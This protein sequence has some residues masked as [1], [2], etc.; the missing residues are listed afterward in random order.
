MLNK[1][2][3]L[4]CM[5]CV[6][7]SSFPVFALK[8]EESL[9]ID[10]D[11][12][13]DS[14]GSVVYD[15]GEVFKIT[16]ISVL[17]SN[18]AIDDFIGFYV[19]MS[20]D[21]EHYSM[22]E[23]VEKSSELGFASTE[24]TY[25]AKPAVY[26]RHIRL[27]FES[28]GTISIDCIKVK[29]YKGNNSEKLSV[30]Y[31]YLTT[32]PF[33]TGD[34]IILEDKENIVLTDGNKDIFITSTSEYT[35][36]DF[37]LQGAYAI[38]SINV[39]SMSSADCFIDGYELLYS[40]DGKKYH[41]Y[42][43]FVNENPNSL[44]GVTNIP[45]CGLPNRNARYIKMILHTSC[46]A[47]ISEIEIFGYAP[48][49]NLDIIPLNI[50]IH[51]YLLGYIDWS[52]YIGDVSAYALYIEKYGFNNVAGL[53]PKAVFDST[54]LEYKN[55]YCE[56]YPFEPER[57]YYIAIT[58]FDLEGN[59]NIRVNPVKI[60]TQSVVGSKPKDIFA[61]NFYTSEL[62]SGDVPHKGYQVEFEDR[63]IQLIDEIGVN[64]NRWWRDHL[65]Q[66]KR[67]A[68]KGISYAVEHTTPRSNIIADNAIGTWM[69]GHQNE[70]DLK[71]ADTIEYYEILKDNYNRLKNIDSRNVLAIPGLGGVARPSL[72]WLEKFYEADGVNGK[73][74]SKNFDY[75]DFH[76][77][78]KID[79]QQIPGIPVSSPE[80]IH[81]MMDELKNVMKKY[82]DEEKPIVITEFGWS[83]FEGRSYI[84][85]VDRI[86]Q[87]NYMVRAYLL[88]M[89]HSIREAYIYNFRDSG[90]DVKNFEHN[91]GIVD[92]FGVPKP[93]YYGIYTLSKVV[94]NAEYI[95]IIPEMDIPY[96]GLRFR[97]K[98]SGK[99]ISAMWTAD[100]QTKSMKLFVSGTQTKLN[101]VG[102]DGSFSCVPV[103]NNEAVVTI[104]GSPIFVYSDVPVRMISVS[105]PFRLENVHSDVIRGEDNIVNII[106]NNSGKGIKGTVTADLPQGWS[107]T[108]KTSFDDLV[109]NIPLTVSVPSNAKDGENSIAININYENGT[110]IP[111]IATFN[112]MESINLSLFPEYD[113]ENGWN[114][115]LL[116]K[117]LVNKPF[118]GEIS[119]TGI[120]S[121][122]LK[123]TQSKYI[124]NLQY[125]DVQK[126]TYPIIKIP[127]KLNA[128]LSISVNSDG[129]TKEITRAFNF[130]PVVNDG[131]KPI[132]DGILSEGEWDTETAVSSDSSLVVNMNSKWTGEDDLSFKLYRK[133]D[134]EFLYIAVDTRDN[135]HYQAGNDVDIWQGDSIQIAIDPER[136]DT[137]GSLQ[138]H[139]F[140]FAL[141]NNGSVIG[142]RW[143]APLVVNQGVFRNYKGTVIR[144]G[145]HTVYE[146]AI[147][148]SEIL[149]NKES[150]PNEGD[151]IGFSCLVNEN[152]GNGRNKWIEFMSGIG[153]GVNTSKFESMILIKK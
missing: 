13:I 107:L 97:D 116:V 79:Y 111:I 22:A 43:F 100:N 104:S 58:F 2:C 77:Y 141:N 122:D 124:E 81:F 151:I 34:D 18:T 115:V 67:F 71:S 136:N 88:F 109:D 112:V 38:E 132:L 52:S 150:V 128:T 143:L 139:Q 51:N 4:V 53:K 31:S 46:I 140:G 11:V 152:D 32:Q 44:N 114:A 148:W 89:S 28:K 95:G 26:T 149:L 15:L 56:Y 101:I 99:H 121:V 134:D 47:S 16:D 39:W 7:F 82:N 125:G 73:E 117:N 142:Y 3:A 144:N 113:A 55:Q 135:I 72:L 92:W 70:P 129:Y 37:K 45:S 76:A 119:V 118:F 87:R 10:N 93:A 66:L 65:N 62:G 74:T 8:S 50:D 20:F 85:P 29:G 49:E 127:D 23:Y 14:Y 19:Y 69:F 27:S 78:T 153:S 131:K 98:Y 102:A 35:A 90:T 64:K 83:T 9:V 41:P 96:Q 138:S 12:Q 63:M 42:G 1:L 80:I 21:G 133:W 123:T 40:L 59:E 30:E 57:T 60:I 25:K 33:L 84:P 5:V 106:R 145:E 91:L 36:I 105:I 86:T 146:L 24:L 94:R 75:L 6:V 130:S 54:S 17:V 103:T 110:K 108:G 61:L 126:L 137:N 48:D 147:P 68:P 120:N